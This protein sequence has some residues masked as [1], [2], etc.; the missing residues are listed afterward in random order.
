[1]FLI[2]KKL[3]SSFLSNWLGKTKTKY[4]PQGRWTALDIHLDASRLGI[5]HTN[6]YLP[7]EESL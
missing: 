1:M 7:F 6:I 3:F 5:W 4:P 2:Y